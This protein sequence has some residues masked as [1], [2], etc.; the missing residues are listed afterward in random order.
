MALL[1]GHEIVV[2]G[3]LLAGADGSVPGLANVE[4]EGYV[5]MWKAASPHPLVGARGTH[6]FDEPDLA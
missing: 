3:A 5:R 6:E 1:T 4:P 2:D